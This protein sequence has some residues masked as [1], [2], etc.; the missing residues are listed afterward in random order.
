MYE[1]VL[2]DLDGTLVDSSAGILTA[3][4]AALGAIGAGGEPSKEQIRR[5]IGRPLSDMPA[6]LGIDL[7]EARRQ[8]FVA[9]YRAVYTRVFRSQTVIYPGVPETLERLAGLRLGVVT[10]KRQDQAELMLEAM[11]LARF[12]GH[13]QGWL[14]GLPPKP[15][16]DLVFMAI[17][18]L[19]GSRQTAIMVGDTENDVLAGKNAG[20]ATCA[21][22]YGFAPRDFLAGLNPDYLVDRFEQVR[23]IV[24]PTGSPA[25]PQTSSAPPRPTG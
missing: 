3:F 12:F 6:A 24:C 10:T 19:G 25:R 1:T 13:I 17:D 7:D 4:Q 15:A 16:P 23:E 2:F 18:A 9:E 20:I 14:E 11:G 8:Q 22:S 21:V 5:L